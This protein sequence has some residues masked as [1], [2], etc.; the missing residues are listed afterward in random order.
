M[1]YNNLSVVLAE[2]WLSAI[3]KQ[4]SADLLPCFGFTLDVLK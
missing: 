1:Q 4:L 3:A 2:Y